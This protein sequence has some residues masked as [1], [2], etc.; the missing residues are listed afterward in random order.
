MALLSKK[1]FAEECSMRTKD[2]AVYISRGKVI[3]DDDGDI[4]T[5]NPINAQFRESKQM[6]KEP[7]KAD[8]VQKTAS[9]PSNNSSKS[10]FPTHLNT[11]SE[12]EVEKKKKDIEKITEEIAILK[13]KKD[14]LHG[15][16]IPTDMVKVIFAQHTKSI[17]VEFNNSLDKILTR[18]SKR[19]GLT[20]DEQA[21]IRKELNEEIN[22]AVDAA[23]EESKKGIKSIIEQFAEKRGKGE[24]K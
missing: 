11:Y 19:K 24:R 22:T 5:K 4:D 7:V 21:E 6:K 1:E 15:I 20:N 18:I 9:S 12:L 8:P 23:I 10:L 16:V 2:L 3:V 13:V 14:K 17:L